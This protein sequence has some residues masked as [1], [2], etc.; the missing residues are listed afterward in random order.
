MA[1]LQIVGTCR[2]SINA[3][4]RNTT[5]DNFQTYVTDVN[6]QIALAPDDLLIAPCQSCHYLRGGAIVRY[7]R[8]I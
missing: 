6:I 1:S 5:H 4:H 8:V 3:V 7:N 2:D